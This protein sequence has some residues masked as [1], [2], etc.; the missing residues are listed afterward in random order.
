[1]KWFTRSKVN[2]KADASM[3]LD[4]TGSVVR[5]ADL[6]HQMEYKCRICIDLGE[7]DARMCAPCDCI[8]SGKYM[9]VTCL[10]EWIKEK[11]AIKCELCGGNYKKKVI[12]LLM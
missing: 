4:T 12:L 2:E 11:R 9:H 3:R 8:G 7:A 5:V 6:S 10:K 1:M